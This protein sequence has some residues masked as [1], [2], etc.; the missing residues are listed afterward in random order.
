MVPICT[1]VFVVTLHDA[2]LRLLALTTVIRHASVLEGAWHVLWSGNRHVCRAA[3]HVW[4]A[5]QVAW[6]GNQVC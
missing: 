6:S 1:A 2:D 5:L 4:D 3:G